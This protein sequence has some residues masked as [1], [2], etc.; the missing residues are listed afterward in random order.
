MIQSMGSGQKR[1]LSSSLTIT[2]CVTLGKCLHLCGLLPP[3]QLGKIPVALARDGTVQAAPCGGAGGCR[4]IPV[5]PQSS[6][7]YRETETDSRSMVG[8][9]SL[10]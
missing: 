4:R 7:I 10:S 8:P 1:H 9:R 2:C 6:L 3:L 5:N